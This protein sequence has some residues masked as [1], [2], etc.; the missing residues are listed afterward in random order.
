MQFL[1]FI[2]LKDYYLALWQIF[3]KGFF[4]YNLCQSF[5]PF[6]PLLSSPMAKKVLLQK[7]SNLTFLSL[8]Q[9]VIAML[10]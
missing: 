8:T 2:T 6:S 10:S 7:I 9:S 4:V 1:Q 5:F 3:I